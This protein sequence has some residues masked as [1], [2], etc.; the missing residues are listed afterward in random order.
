M[1]GWIWADL[2]SFVNVFPGRWHNTVVQLL[3][4]CGIVGLAAYLFHRVQTVRLFLQNRT[5]ENV[6]IAIS[7]LALLGMSLLDCHFFNIGPAMIYSCMLAFAENK[8][9]E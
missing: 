6:Y 8:T 5:V 3:A 9:K 2:D 1:F 4:S 7:I